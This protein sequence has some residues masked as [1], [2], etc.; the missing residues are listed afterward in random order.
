MQR[1]LIVGTMVVAGLAWS[2]S[3]SQVVTGST[4]GSYQTGNGGEFTVKAVGLD[5]SDYSSKASGK[6]AG[7]IGNVDTFQTFCLEATSPP[8]YIEYRTEYN[9]VVNTKAIYGGVG[10]DG[11]VLS[12]GTGWLYS[13]FATG[14]LASYAFEGT[15]AQRKADAGLLQN[16]IWWLED[17]GVAYNGDNKFM[18]AVATHFGGQALAKA[19]GAWLYNVY[20]LNM[21]KADGTRAQDQVYYNVPDGGLTVAMLG[22]G[23]AGLGLIARRRN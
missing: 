20:A 4:W 13:Q 21:T 10:P 23:L 16:A 3:A 5:L 11:D 19:D 12:K 7:V 2:L 22:M 1:R 6:S 15:D 17:E 9:V 14:T 8:E 18:E